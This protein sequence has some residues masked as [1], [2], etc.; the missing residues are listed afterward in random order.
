MSNEDR[1]EIVVSI[2]KLLEESYELHEKFK[3]ATGIR[4]AREAKRLA[5]THRLLVPYLRACFHITNDSQSTFDTEAGIENAIEIISLLES[6]DRARQFQSDYDEDEYAHTVHWLSACG[7]DNLAVHTAH[8]HGYNSPLVH[9]AVDDG[10]H[11]CRRTG[12]LECI[13][14]FR[15]YATDMCLASGDLEMAFHYANMCV[16]KYTEHSEHDR[17]WVGQ[18]DIARV[19]ME[20]GDIEAAI[21]ACIAAFDFADTYHSP[22]TA[23]WNTA[24]LLKQL[25]PL[26]DR[27]GEYEGILAAKA[28]V[29]DPAETPS[30]EEDP[31]SYIDS[32]LAETLISVCERKYPEAIGGYAQIERFLLS[33]ETVSFWFEIRRRRIAAMILAQR[34]NVTISG[35]SLGALSEELRAKAEKA[36]EWSAIA[37]LDAMMSPDFPVSPLGI[38]FPVD[39]GPFAPADRLLFA[40]PPLLAN[41]QGLTQID[42][43]GGS[44]FETKNH[45]NE[46]KLLEEK[47]EIF[48]RY[49]KI[50]GELSKFGEVRQEAADSEK[51]FKREDEYRE[52]TRAAVEKAMNEDV[53]KCEY[54]FEAGMLV[55]FIAQ[56]EMSFFIDNPGKFK[57]I[58]SW[59]DGLQTRFGT[60]GR[61]LSAIALLRYESATLRDSDTFSRISRKQ[62]Q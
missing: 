17:R 38:A 1:E 21:A 62:R 61:L 32:F 11:V 48:K 58:W 37:A 60:D 9:G 10:F 25:L 2:Y 55:F 45:K 4:V 6:E 39:I 5:K 18:R 43:I 41:I 50:L 16:T 3:S 15:E 24:M 30:R 13:D 56:A 12:K 40:R 14:C 22:R 42:H 8:K 47:S 54:P 46:E 49:E 7:Y 33:H 31:S 27:L 59:S 26:A 23:N 20:R 52:W 44:K 34:N 36:C 53:R 57:S 35:P 19:C 29:I 51:P 28:V